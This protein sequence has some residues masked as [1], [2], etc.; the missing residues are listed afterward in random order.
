[1]AHALGFVALLLFESASAAAPAPTG[2]QQLSRARQATIDLDLDE[3]EKALRLAL[4]SPGNDRTTLL[5]ILE[6]QGIVA[7]LGS[8]GQK[9]IEA[10]KMLLCLDPRRKLLGDY[11]PRVT[12]PWTAATRWVADRG[13]LNVSALPPEQSQGTL[14]SLSIKVASDPL[15]LG[16]RVRFHVRPEGADWATVDA[17]VTAG[18]AQAPVVGPAI[19]WWAEYLGDHEA[20]LATV[21]APDLP[22]E[23]R[24]DGKGAEV[25]GVERP[26]LLGRL[27]GG[28]VAAL[29]LAAAGGAAL[30]TGVVFGVMSASARAQI[31]AA[32][33]G[34]S[35]KVAKITQQ[36]ELELEKRAITDA[37]AANWLF[38]GGA[39]L[40]VTG[41]ALWWWGGPVA[42]TPAPGGAVVSGVFP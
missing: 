12:A 29:G 19:R 8:Q 33:P 30:V 40:A 32:A 36:R 37:T 41:V 31:A 22:L 18:V 38:A 21:G 35:E 5:G 23:A 17:S 15:S 42:V 10:F 11:P 1:M 13:A 9:A 14:K 16:R 4:E 2:A 28:R 20:V 25:A 6:Q 27:P 26:G 34:P 7:G 39:A 24:I 3:A